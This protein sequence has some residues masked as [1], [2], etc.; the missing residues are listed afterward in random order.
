LVFCTISI[1]YYFIAKYPI[2]IS[3][4]RFGYLRNNL[5]FASHILW[6]RSSGMVIAKQK[7][8]NEIIICAILHF[9]D[10]LEYF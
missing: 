5:N 1:S 7:N 10:E 6:I 3:K 4:K 2:G 9:Y 8:K